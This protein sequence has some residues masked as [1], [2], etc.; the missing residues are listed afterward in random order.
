[1]FSNQR[2]AQVEIDPDGPVPT[3]R[4]RVSG[5]R[6]GAAPMAATFLLRFQERLNCRK[7]REIAKT[8]TLTETREARDQDRAA[9]GYHILPRKS[10]CC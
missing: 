4:W 6:E 3:K 7:G 8:Q 2:D 5:P 1:M 10:S 9:A